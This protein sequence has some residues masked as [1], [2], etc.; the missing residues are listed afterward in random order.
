VV[1]D[2]GTGPGRLLIELAR[3]RPDLQLI[4]VDP[5]SHMLALA[6][7]NIDAAGVTI[8]LRAGEAAVLPVDDA[9]VDVAVSTVTMHHWPDIAAG[10]TEL[11]RV[12][13]PGGHLFVYDFRFVSAAPLAQA[14]RNW[15]PP[16]TPHHTSVWAA[17]WLPVPVF[18]RHHLISN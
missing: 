4:G 17:P 18:T 14:A 12:L 10:I 2:V 15:N 11:G 7:R 6:R 16:S 8:S 1:L 3:R 9:T 13:R 5:A